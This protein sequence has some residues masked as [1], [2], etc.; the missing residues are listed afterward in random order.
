MRR[1]NI[2]VDETG[3][4][5]FGKESS[6]L[7]GVSFTFHEQN[8]DIMFE[9][10][11]LN[12]RLDRI[13]YTDMIHMADLIMRRE[14]YKN[15][16]I[17]TRKSIFNTIYQFSRRIPVKYKTIII[18]K[19]YTNDART[20]RQRLSAEINKMIKEHEMYFN[21]FDKIVMYYDNGQET[22]GTILDSIFLRFEGFEHRVN[23]DH[24]E[25]RLFQVSDMLTYIDKYDYK[26]KNKMKITQAEKYFFSVEDIRRIL[27][28]LDKKRF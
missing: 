14:D 28:E 17:A 9:L 21:R 5:G 11:K 19:R 13:G 8:D 26:Y 4:F 20:L 22:L 15:F 18:D 12:A 24:K 23:F 10:N 25:K 16:D 6:L 3:E 2:F 1:L 7:Y 27:K